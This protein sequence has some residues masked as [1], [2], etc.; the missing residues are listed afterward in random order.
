VA[1]GACAPLAGS[2]RGVVAEQRVEACEEGVPQMLKRA[3]DFPLLIVGAAWAGYARNDPGIWTRLESQLRELVAQGHRVW[4]LPRVPEFA[5]FDAD[6]P[7]KR[8]RVGD[9]LRCPT[10]LAPSDAGSDTNT[11]LRAIAQRTP[12]VRFLPLHETLCTN[13]TCPV[14]DAQGNYLYADPSH[15]SVYG[16]LHL[17]AELL[18]GNRLPDISE[19]VSPQFDSGRANR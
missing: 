18:R 7:A 2:L 3:R 8:V 5:N 16:S 14:A 17:A 11:R 1:L 12:G 4:L 19:S 13:A 9:W 15:L 6:C 10:T